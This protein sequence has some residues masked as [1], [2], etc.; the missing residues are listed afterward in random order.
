MVDRDDLRSD[1]STANVHSC[2][3]EVLRVSGVAEIAGQAGAARGTVQGYA[4]D[5]IAGARAERRITR[6]YAGI[7]DEL[8]AECASRTGSSAGTA[9]ATYRRAR[10]LIRTQEEP[11][12]TWARRPRRGRKFGARCHIDHR[13][14]LDRDELDCRAAIARRCT[15]IGPGSRS[16]RGTR[17]GHAIGSAL[18]ITGIENVIKIAPRIWLI[19]PC[20]PHAFTF[21]IKLNGHPPAVV[22]EFDHG[23][24]SLAFFIA[25]QVRLHVS[26]LFPSVR[27]TQQECRLENAAVEVTG[28]QACHRRA[29]RASRH[30]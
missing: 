8:V 13:A 18:L 14:D 9:N 6:T 12:L 30:R 16:A 20:G 3:A 29:G 28:L 21:E 11:G 19:D 4:G 24:G 10:K 1:K 2:G 22:S 23:L 7:G 26:P 25:E 17:E 15:L 27:R 5:W